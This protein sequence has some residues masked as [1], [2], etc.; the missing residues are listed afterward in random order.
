MCR[1]PAVGYWVTLSVK[2][3]LFV[4][5]PEVPETVTV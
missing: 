3:V 5:V 2:A 4:T 1:T